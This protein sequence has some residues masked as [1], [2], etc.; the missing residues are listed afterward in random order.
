MS[1]NHVE[2]RSAHHKVNSLYGHIFTW[3]TTHHGQLATC[4][5]LTFESTAIGSKKAEL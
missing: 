1:I 5:E 2:Y 3:L 4:D